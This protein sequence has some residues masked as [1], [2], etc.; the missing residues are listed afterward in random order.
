MFTM[1]RVSG[2]AATVKTR[3]IR[4]KFNSHGGRDIR[5]TPHWTPLSVV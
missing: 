2:K 5:C 4:D 3:I 1:R